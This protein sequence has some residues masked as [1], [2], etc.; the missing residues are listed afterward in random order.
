MKKIET[1]KDLKQSIRFLEIKQA[2]QLKVL[3]IQLHASYENLTPAHFFEDVLHESDVPT[4]LKNELIS[5]SVGMAAGYVTKKLAFGNSSNPIKQ[6]IGSL[7][8]TGVSNVVSNHVDDIKS[9]VK[10]I[11]TPFTKKQSS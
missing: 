11:A 10:L 8:Q 7:L 3:K 4:S 2:Q 9:I 6:I 1:A 5:T